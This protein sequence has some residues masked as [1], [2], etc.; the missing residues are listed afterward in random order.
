MTMIFELHAIAVNH[1]YNFS[2]Y[3]SILKIIFINN[4]LPLQISFI[5]LVTISIKLP[6]ILLLVRILLFAPT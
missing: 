6:M 3:F 1:K 2:R 5:I 4:I